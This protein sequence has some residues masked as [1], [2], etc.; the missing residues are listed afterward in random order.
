MPDTTPPTSPTELLNAW[1]RRLSESQFAHYT[2]GRRLSGANLCLGVPVMVLS[3]IV[4]AATLATFDRPLNQSAR[5]TFGCITLAVALMA[6]LQTFLRFSDRSE[7]HRVIA[8][9][10]GSI[11][12]RAEQLLV[13]GGI[14]SDEDITELRLQTD[15][16]TEEAPQIN[17][18]VIKSI[19]KELGYATDAE[20]SVIATS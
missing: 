1:H 3:A 2:A 8:A 20:A 12:R 16:I 13:G 6:S 4:A 14:V 5:V 17:H 10:Y 19:R 7:R 11:K 9:R 15:R 18:S